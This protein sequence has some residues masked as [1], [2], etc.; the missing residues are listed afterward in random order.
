MY[1]LHSLPGNKYTL[2]KRFE[3]SELWI[4][5]VGKLSAELEPPGIPGAASRRPARGSQVTEPPHSTTGIQ[6]LLQTYYTVDWM[7]FKG[8]SS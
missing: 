1:E 6:A 2:L 7:I 8:L 3:S 5:C 4:S